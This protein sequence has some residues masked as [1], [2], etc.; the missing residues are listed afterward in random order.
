MKDR[1][2]RLFAPWAA[3][4]QFAEEEAFYRFLQRRCRAL[5]TVRLALFAAAAVLL[6]VGYAM[7]SIQPWYAIAAG[8]LAVSLGVTLAI[9]QM[10]KQLPKEM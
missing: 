6:I 4:G 10:E 2:C 7:P 5:G 8:V 9:A 1:L 3:G